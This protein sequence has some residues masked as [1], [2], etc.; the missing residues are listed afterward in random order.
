DEI[1]DQVRDDE[2]NQSRHAE[3]VGHPERSRG[4]ASHQTKSNPIEIINA[5]SI[6]DQFNFQELEKYLPVVDYFLFDTKGQNP[7]GNGFTFDWRVLK[8]YPFQKPYFLSGG[9]GLKEGEKIKEFQQLNL[10]LYAIDVNS[11][12]ETEPGRKNIEDLIFF[13]KKINS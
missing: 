10:P 1:P 9:I 4:T 11:K 8:E 6:K 3:L 5:F 13:T 7:G 2:Y 12:F